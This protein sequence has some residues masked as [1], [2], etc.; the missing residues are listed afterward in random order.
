MDLCG[1]YTWT[2]WKTQ[3]PNFQCLLVTLSELI[4]V[5]LFHKWLA[6]FWLQNASKSILV[7]AL[8]LPD[9]IG[10]LFFL[11]YSNWSDL[12]WMCHSSFLCLHEKIL[13][14]FLVG[15][16]DIC[17][18][19]ITTVNDT[20]QSPTLD[21]HQ[22]S[23]SRTFGCHAFKYELIAKFLVYIIRLF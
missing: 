20:S 8:F 3:S 2:C 1:V 22:K 12:T 15:Y 23:F 4:L 10:R 21:K 7:N 16:T 18:L 11:W 13:L 9:A 14:D 19:I 5:V 17:R 6:K